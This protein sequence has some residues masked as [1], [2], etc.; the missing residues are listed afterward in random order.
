MDFYDEIANKSKKMIK[1]TLPLHRMLE[2]MYRR[3]RWLQEDRKSLQGQVRALETQIEMMQVELKKRKVKIIAEVLLHDIENS[4]N[5]C[6][7]YT[8][9]S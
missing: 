8:Y 5:F 3:N 2:H 9:F 4:L 1:R 6:L 7:Y